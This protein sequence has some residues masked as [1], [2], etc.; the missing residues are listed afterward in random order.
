M[1]GWNL[2]PGF[3]TW[4]EDPALAFQHK[5][6][7]VVAQADA[8]GT[9]DPGRTEGQPDRFRGQIAL[10]QLGHHA[11]DARA[12]QDRQHRSQPGRRTWGDYWHVDW[13]L[14]T[15]SIILWGRPGCLF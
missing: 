14:V 12:S 15:I 2:E 6:P 4:G 7:V 10:D 3:F 11:A 13:Y 5:P 1:A 8:G 9:V